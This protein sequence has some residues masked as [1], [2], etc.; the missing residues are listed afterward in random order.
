MTKAA[1]MSGTWYVLWATMVGCQF[2]TDEAP[3]KRRCPMTN[4]ELVGKI[5]AKTAVNRARK[6]CGI[7]DASEIETSVVASPEKILP[8][9]TPEESVWRI[10]LEGIKFVLTDGGTPNVSSHVKSLDVFLSSKTGQVMAARSVWPEKIAGTR[11]PSIEDQERQMKRIDQTFTGLPD[12]APKLTLADA[13]QQADAVSQAK[14][15]IAYYV[16]E[17]YSEP[18]VGP[19]PVWVIHAWGI[20]PFLPKGGSPDNVPEDARNHLRTII[21]AET[22]KSYGSDTIPQPR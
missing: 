16:L 6:I 1:Q 20:P 11:F 12:A 4:A 18:K 10:R 21:N 17:A 7:V 22:G 9:V 15:I 13:L 14:Q 5:D 19:R 3:T 8:F 2:F